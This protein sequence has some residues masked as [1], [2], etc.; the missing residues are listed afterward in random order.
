MDKI[1]EK[2][3]LL[4]LWKNANHGTALQAYAFVKV[5]SEMGFEGEYILYDS[6]RYLQFMD[7]IRINI[8]KLVYFIKGGFV[9]SDF[10]S[11]NSYFPLMDFWDSIPHSTIIYNK[12]TC[13]N[14]TKYYNK[15][16]VAG[17]QVW[18]WNISRVNSFYFLDGLDNN[19]LKYS[20][21]PSFGSAFLPS[22]YK[23]LLVKV[24]SRFKYIG[25]RDVSHCALIRKLI[26]RDVV[27]TVD[28]V[29]LLSKEFW[30]GF[31]EIWPRLPLKY[32]L[33]YELGNSKILR[34]YAELE[35]KSRNL[36]MVYMSSSSEEINLCEISP[37]NFV[38]IFE[39]AN[40]V[41]T[42]SYHG[43][44]FSIIF[45][46]M[47]T[48]F[49]KR[50]GNKTSFDNWRVHELCSS[51]GIQVGSRAI[52]DNINMDSLNIKIAQSK[53]FLYTILKN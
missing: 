22:K 26:N 4:T 24:L 15:Y 35:A 21:S 6:Y 47:F 49:F 45:G 1:G 53:E 33:C 36:D 42:D 29:L 18:N 7:K 8:N 38:Y 34:K 5:I 30:H 19:V 14:T 40:F 52:A 37:A 51:I 44:L 46:K 20:Y 31:S 9:K 2:I 12:K 41:V 17:D 48:P 3:G 32:L 27:N 13:C 50:R 11:S 28:P 43:M 23:K 25:C 16:I 10:E 39:K